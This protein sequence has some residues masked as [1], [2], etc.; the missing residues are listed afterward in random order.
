[1]LA[2][3]WLHIEFGDLRVYPYHECRLIA[4]HLYCFPHL[5]SDVL[6]INGRTDIDGIIYAGAH[7]LID[8]GQPIVKFCCTHA[9]HDAPCHELR[10]AHL[11]ARTDVVRTTIHGDA[12]LKISRTAIRFLF[13]MVEYYLICCFLKGDGMVSK[14]IPFENL[15]NV[16]AP[17][18]RNISA[19]EKAKLK[20]NHKNRTNVYKPRD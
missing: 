18:R 2:G 16:Y 3:A 10:S 9:V 12:D 14:K 4:L 11:D 8:D 15:N 20:N 19:A 7:L 6:W 5:L 13:V 17:K 1:M